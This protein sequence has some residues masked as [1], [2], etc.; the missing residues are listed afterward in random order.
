MCMK[1]LEAQGR[2]SPAEYNF[3][4]RGGVVLDRENQVDNP[5]A[6][7]NVFEIELKKD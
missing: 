3:F 4:L 2:V 1:I 6:G 7:N 5:C